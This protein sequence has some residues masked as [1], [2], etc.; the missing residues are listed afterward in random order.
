MIKLANKDERTEIKNT[1]INL[2][3]YFTKNYSD[4]IDFKPQVNMNALL[5]SIYFRT[6]DTKDIMIPTTDFTSNNS[7]ITVPNYG[8][9]E[10]NKLNKYIKYLKYLQNYFGEQTLNFN[11]SLKLPTPIVLRDDN[12]FYPLLAE[13]DS[14]WFQF[15][16]I[17]NKTFIHVFL[18]LDDN[19]EIKV[20]AFG[21]YLFNC[22]YSDNLIYKKCVNDYLKKLLPYAG[23]R[24]DKVI[25][26]DNKMFIKVIK[27]EDYN[28]NSM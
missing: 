17:Q 10:D 21:H 3:Q 15:E 23:V 24:F 1:V 28:E 22:E 18:E 19:N 6:C 27:E 8:Y 5:N 7:T 12:K 2:T 13:F 25:K 16:G 20:S 11:F 9:I 4:I 26:K 14:G